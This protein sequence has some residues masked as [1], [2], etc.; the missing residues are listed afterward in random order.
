MALTKCPDC[1]KE[2]SDQ[3][4]ACPNCGR[5]QAT[6]PHQTGATSSFK[7]KEV[8]TIQATGKQYKAMEVV[9][10]IGMLTGTVSCVISKSPGGFTAFFLFAGLALYIAGRFGAWWHH[11]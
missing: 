3:A 7:H 9:G 1:G 5:P 8:V 10:V 11:K 6:Q 2:I 4:P